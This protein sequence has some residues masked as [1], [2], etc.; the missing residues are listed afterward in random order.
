MKLR[1][2]GLIS[3]LV[4]GL[5]VRPLPVEAQK[6][7][8]VYRIGYLA[9]I[10]YKARKKAFRQGLLE[11]GY[12]EGQNI[13]IEWRYGNRDRFPQVATELVRLKV[14]LIV[15]RGTRATRAAKKATRTIPIVMVNVGDAV[16]SGIVASLARPGGNVTGLTTLNSELAGKR[17]ELLK[18]AFPQVS[19]VAV[20]FDPN[21]PG[22]T[23]RL[24][25]MKVA[26][27]AL[28]VQ[29][30][31][32]EVRR[33]YDFENSFRAAVKERAEALIIV[34]FGFWRHR[35]RVLDLEVKTKL[36]V[37]YT[38]GRFVPAGGLM[39]YD[40]DRL[41]QFR[42][43]A[44]YVDKILKGR[45]PGNI[46]V[47]QPTKFNLVINLKTVKQLGFTIPPEVLY[48]ATKVIK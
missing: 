31:S 7:A 21:R 44:T 30:Q 23:S 25:L 11:L 1:T 17:L 4:L 48:Q 40:A 43:A 41:K 35:A 8:K 47:E 36:P 18:E 12:I 29:L 9:G 27:P 16:G 19:R 6:A 5:L 15:S 32:L 38:D 39:S 42:R 20:L 26:A 28:G 14:D 10:P 13:V 2:I 34:T 22:S 46:P 3:I 33:P 24:R 45:K 37:M